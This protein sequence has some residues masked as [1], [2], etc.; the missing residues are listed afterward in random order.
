M[1]NISKIHLLFF[2]LWLIVSA[3]I[4]YQAQFISDYLTH[5]RGM[6][7]AEYE[8]PSKHV[9]TLCFYLGLLFLNEIFY[10]STRFTKQHLIISYFVCAILP[11]LFS[12]IALIGS[13]HAPN[14][15]FTFLFSIFITTLF[16]LIFAP[17][18]VYRLR[19]RDLIRLNN[20]NINP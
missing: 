1:R 12:L 7:Q 15:Y 13:M 20:R 6:T 8:Y 11:L 17:I 18:F 19:K 2:S 4:A 5:V 10:L 16:Q 14:Y 3:I 9:I